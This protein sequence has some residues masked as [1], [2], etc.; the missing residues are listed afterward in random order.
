VDLAERIVDAVESVEMV[1]FVTSGTEAAMSASASPAATGRD[2]IVKFAGGY[3]GMPMR[4]SPSRARASPP[5]GS[6]LTRVP[7]RL[8]PAPSCCPTTTSSGHRA[9]RR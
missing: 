8:S 2:R 9:F 3:H 5:W 7:P 1:R 4:F 6:G